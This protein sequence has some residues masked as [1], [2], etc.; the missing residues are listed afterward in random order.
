MIYFSE[1]FFGYGEM[2]NFKQWSLAHFAPIVFAIV[3]ILLICKYRETLRNSKHG[4]TVGFIYCRN[5]F[6][7]APFLCRPRN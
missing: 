3:A 6:L 4:K 2:G 7:L 5:V 1:G